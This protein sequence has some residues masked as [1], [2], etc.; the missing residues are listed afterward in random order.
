MN[1]SV[2][3]LSR[4]NQMTKALIALAL[5]SLALTACIWGGPGYGDRG[6]GYRGG[7]HSDHAEYQSDRGPPGGWNH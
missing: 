3:E 2:K 6:Y 7:N 1:C 5:L 4:E